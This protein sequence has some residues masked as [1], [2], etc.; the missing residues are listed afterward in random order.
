MLALE[1]GPGGK[2]A[3]QL[4]VPHPAAMAAE[5]GQG[6]AEP[7]SQPSGWV[8]PAAWNRSAD[9][10]CVAAMKLRQ[11]LKNILA[12]SGRLMLHPQ[13]IAYGADGFDLHGH[14]RR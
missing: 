14:L 8:L 5:A 1:R 9:T 12:N 2:L 6:Q 4:G 7:F 11:T 3:V 13:S 10:T